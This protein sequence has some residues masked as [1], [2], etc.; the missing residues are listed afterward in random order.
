MLL[1]L[2]TAPFRTADY[3]DVTGGWPELPLAGGSLSLQGYQCVSETTSLV[4]KKGVGVWEGREEGNIG[5]PCH[6]PVPRRPTVREHQ[7][8]LNFEMLC[9]QTA[10]PSENTSGFNNSEPPDCPI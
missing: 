10:Q 8:T 3:C 9:V 2:A 5:A 6:Q 4:A 1:S 7:Q